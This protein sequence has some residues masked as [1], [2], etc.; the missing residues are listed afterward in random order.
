MN[1]KERFSQLVEQHGIRH[2]AFAAR[3]D[4]DF[5]MAVREATAHLPDLSFAERVVCA[6]EDFDPRCQNGSQKK[7]ISITKGWSFCGPAGRCACAKA[8]ISEKSKTN[9]DHE[10]RL[11]KTRKTLQ[12]RYG[13][14][15]PGCLPQAK[16]AH[17]EFYQDPEKV[18]RAL[19]KGRN[20]MLARYGVDSAF[21]FAVDRRAIAQRNMSDET[22]AILNDR[23]AFVLFVTDKSSDTIANQLGIDT[24]TVNNYVRHYDCKTTFAS[25]FENEIAAFL[26]SCNLAFN[27]SDRTI[28][29]PC[30]LDFYIPDHSLA[31][32][33]NGLYWHSSQVVDDRYHI[34]KWRAVDAS[35][36]RL[37]MI[38][39]DEWVDRPETIKN[40]IRNLCGLSDRGV[41]A[42]QLSV[43]AISS[44]QAAAFC[45][46]YH[47]QG[48]PG[49]CV[50]A[51]GAFFGEA[52]VGVITFSRQRTTGNMDLTRFCTDGKIYAGL[53][54]KLLK[55]ARTEIN[56][57]IVTFADLR[58]S[59]G[60]LYE[61]CGFI[62]EEMIRPDYKY[63]KR[64]KTFHK[65]LF[66][67]SRIAKKF[68]I[69]MSDKT[70]REAMAQLGYSRIYDCGKIRYRLP[71]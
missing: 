18:E 15:N 42:R 19:T 8:V 23:D 45:E 51:Y 2:W 37:L 55:A 56:E 20:T 29:S 65:S 52:L 21:K 31:I 64:N 17:Q 5:M 70:E 1:I 49:P 60:G 9:V 63:V 30:E 57:D 58:Y 47:I 25:S 22:K 33:F 14:D 38:N 24:T 44:M 13:T 54:S 36:N 50:A 27:S 6:V 7:L 3:K 66:T 62:K 71:K 34:D 12:Q 53:F 32:E 40:K 10:A 41:G 61:R 48:R 67:K 11:A 46:L 59:D 43:S 35:K 39:E 4:L 16:L 28:I 68:E 26:T 69:D